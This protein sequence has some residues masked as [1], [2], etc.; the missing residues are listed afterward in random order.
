[1][2]DFRTWLELVLQKHKFSFERSCRYTS[3]VNH[4][5]CTIEDFVNQTCQQYRGQGLFELETPRTL[6]LKLNGSGQ[7]T[8]KSSLQFHI[9]M[10][11][12]VLCLT[13]GVLFNLRLTGLDRIDFE[14]HHDPDTLFDDSR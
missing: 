6:E 5:Q 4:E 7:I 11:K 1:M 3:K 13:S 8:F 2:V 10:L 12:H 9:K 14:R